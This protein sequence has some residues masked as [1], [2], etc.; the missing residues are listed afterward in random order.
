[1]P[2]IKDMTRQSLD[3]FQAI[4]NPKTPPPAVVQGAVLGSNRY[5][6][7][8]LPPFNSSP[9]SL[10]QFNES[11]TVPATRV[12][13]LPAATQ[14]GTAKAVTIVT[15]STSSSG[16]GGG[17]S[18]GGS[19]STPVVVNVPSL[20]TG[21]T[22]NTIIQAAPAFQL[23]SVSSSQ[24]VEVRLYGSALAQTSDT[25]RVIDTAVPFETAQNVITDVALDTAP[26][27]WTWQNRVGNNADSPQSSNLYVSVRGLSGAALPSAVVTILYAPLIQ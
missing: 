25:P 27:K 23:L 17:S 18:T 7:C 14:M 8:P 9:D 10:R 13:P 6:R 22:Y 4:E 5:I 11:G 15:G 19:V 12:I 20:A 1:M 26:Y 2:A 16:G 24:P 3:G 21:S